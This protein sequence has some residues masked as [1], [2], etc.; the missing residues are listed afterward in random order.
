MKKILTLFFAV[1]LFFVAS[2]QKNIYDFAVKG[3]D[4]KDVKLSEYRG[5]VLLIVNTATQCGFTPQ[6]NDLQH[7]YLK[8]ADSGFVVLDFPCN[9]FGEQA[10]GSIEEIHSFCTS[11]Y[12]I[13][14]PQFDKIDVNGENADPLFVWL[15]SQK[16]FQGFDQ[17]DRIGKY[18]HNAF[19]KEDP[20]YAENPDIK[21]NFTKF[22][23]DQN[24][25]VVK[26]YEPTTNIDI[27]FQD[28]YE[29]IY[30]YRIR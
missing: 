17:N 26:R 9:Q 13:T 11:N 25:N 24:G 29:L 6:Y 21:W 3:Q 8:F 28:V 18:L 19:L 16:G 10:P 20:N 1:S 14:F 27:I 12:N 15:K 4:G 30:K 23:V 22:L 7:L 2:A 5:R